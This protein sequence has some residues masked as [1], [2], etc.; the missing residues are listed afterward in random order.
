M[1]LLINTIIS[2]KNDIGQWFNFKKIQKNNKSF[3]WTQDR[4]QGKP[5]EIF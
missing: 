1:Q 2:V 3:A 5:E 4:R